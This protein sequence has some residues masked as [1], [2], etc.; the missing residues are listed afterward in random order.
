MPQQA[1]LQA[2]AELGVVFLLFLIGLELSWSRLWALRRMVFGLGGS[3]VVITGTVIALFA[4]MFGNSAEAAVI[5]GAGLALSSTAIVMQL[6]IERD[7]LGTSLGQTSFS[8][9]LFQDFYKVL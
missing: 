9:L 7:R 6:L 1:A 5:L 3:Q 2:L 8:I 4:Y